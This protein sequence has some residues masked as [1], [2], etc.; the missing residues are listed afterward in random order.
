MMDPKPRQD[1]RRRGAGRSQP[2]AAGEASR[3]A[4]ELAARDEEMLLAEAWKAFDDGLREAR[5]FLA[6]AVPAELVPS[7]A[8]G[9][10]RGEEP[11][12]AGVPDWRACRA[13][14]DTAQL[15]RVMIQNWKAD[16]A[17]LDIGDVKLEL[18]PA[19]SVTLWVG[20][21]NPMTFLQRQE[22]EPVRSG[23]A[24]LY[25]DEPLLA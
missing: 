2:T 10:A 18:E 23:F 12:P 6:G 15:E 25:D 3:L 13:E 19:Q 4:A 5:G 21:S 11:E 9:A 17:L 14:N 8:H 20:R 22:D 16:S 1:A 7:V 24:L